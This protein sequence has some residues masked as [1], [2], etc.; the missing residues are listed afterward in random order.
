MRKKSV[1]ISCRIDERLHEQLL[2]IKDEYEN[3]SLSDVINTA[4]SEYVKI[5][6]GKKN[7]EII[8]THI[9]EAINSS[10]IMS[11]RTMKN[12][13]S[14]LNDRTELILKI[15]SNELDLSAEEVKEVSAMLTEKRRVNI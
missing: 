15:L 6:T 9:V 10:V 12:N 3:I 8:N 2:C 11:T 7:L 13:I 14:A 1:R 5:K 4:L